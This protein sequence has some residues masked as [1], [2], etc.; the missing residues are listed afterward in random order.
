[1][2]SRPRSSPSGER[3]SRAASSSATT[4]AACSRKV[5]PA[6]VSAAPRVVRVS[7]CALSSLS[8]RESRRLTMDFGSPSRRAAPDTPPASATATKVSKSARSGTGVPL[9][10]TAEPRLTR[11][12]CAISGTRRWAPTEKESRP[13]RTFSSSTAAPPGRDS[14]SR[15]L[16]ADAVSKLLEADPP[17]KVTHRDLGENPPPHLISQTLNGVRGDRRPP[18]SSSRL[19]AVR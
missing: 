19:A 12:V 8:S 3:L 18:K 10:A 13:C 4:R 15:V 2:R 9:S 11:L 16:V 7:S 5:A 1:M 17:R 14:V 6:S